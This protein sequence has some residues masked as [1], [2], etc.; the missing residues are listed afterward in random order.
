MGAPRKPSSPPKPAAEA[1]GTR[2]DAATAR[3]AVILADRAAKAASLS[4]AKA[5]TSGRPPALTE[6]E[7]LK[8]L[9]QANARHD[10]RL[11]AVAAKGK[12][13][14]TDAVLAAA[15]RKAARDDPDAESVSE[16][17]ADLQ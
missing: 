2:V 14:G 3:R 12:S 17:G 10:A 13:L 8:K 15:K 5:T 1:L 6:E 7:L 4:P 9:D 11:A 16:D